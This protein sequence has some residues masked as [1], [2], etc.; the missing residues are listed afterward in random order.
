MYDQNGPEYIYDA[1]HYRDLAG[2]S[3][4]KWRHVWKEVQ[5]WPIKMWNGMVP[6]DVLADLTQVSTAWSNRQDKSPKHALDIVRGTPTWGM[7]VYDP[8]TGKAAAWTVGQPLGGK[9]AIAVAGHWNPDVTFPC[10]D[11]SRSIHLCDAQL[12]AGRVFTTGGTRGDTHMTRA[13]DKLC[14]VKKLDVYRTLDARKVTKDDWY[15]S[16]GC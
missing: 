10:K 8:I 2:G 7:V 14:P 9:Q 3:W 12:M 4:K 15:A 1:E 13:K 16:R 5:R 11:A 6:P